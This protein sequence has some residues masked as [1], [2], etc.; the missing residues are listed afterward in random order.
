MANVNPPKRST[1]RGRRRSWTLI[2]RQ[3]Q[4]ARL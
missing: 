2:R 4:T 1:T 3:R